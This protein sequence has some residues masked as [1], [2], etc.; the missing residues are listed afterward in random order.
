MTRIASGRRWCSVFSFC[1]TRVVTF[2]DGSEAYRGLT[3]FAEHVGES[4]FE[5]TSLSLGRA[6]RTAFC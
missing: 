1:A 3:H 2:G 4:G 6:I 5:Y